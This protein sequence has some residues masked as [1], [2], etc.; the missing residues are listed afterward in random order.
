MVLNIALEEK[1]VREGEAYL[2]LPRMT[3]A[4]FFEFCQRNPTLNVERNTQGDEI[5]TAPADSYG[6]TRNMEIIIDLGNWNRNLETPGLVFGPAGAFTLPNGAERAPDA[7]WIP[8][9]HWGALSDEQRK[10][11][12]EI[13]PDF[14]VELM[15]PSDTLPRM[16]TKMDEWM[17]NG[18]KLGLL[19][20]RTRRMVYVYR[21]GQSEPV[22]LTDPIEV[23][24]E[25]ELPGFV[26][27]MARVF[28]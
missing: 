18:V 22:E 14:V 26:L 7:A 16:K 17:E 13:C 2:H 25:P 15:L 9:E 1:F 23:S 11:F 4:E 27:Q 12:A 24:C 19:I 3:R 6:E 21:A 28:A 5:L 20:H 8:K 10:G